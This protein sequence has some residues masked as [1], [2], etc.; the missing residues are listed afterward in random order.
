LLKNLVYKI[1]FVILF[2]NCTLYAKKELIESQPE[3]LFQYDKL[4]KSHEDLA[5]QVEFN[6]A[7][8]QLEK[9]NY[10]DAIEILKRTSAVLPVPSYLN[11]G[12][13]YYKLDSIDNA[14]V[15]LNK[16]YENEASATDNTYSY[17][18]ACFYLYQISK[19]NKYLDTIVKVAKR[20]KKL[21][22]H[23]KRMLADT[24]IILKEYRKS[25]KVLDK[26]DFAMDL[27]KALIHIKLKNYEK[28]NILLQK[29]QE[30]TVNP[31]TLNQILW[32]RVFLDLKS[33]NIERLRENLDNITERKSIFKSNQDLPLEIYFNQNKYTP[34]QYLNFVT[35]FSPD[36]KMD[37]IFYFAPFIFSDSQE[38]IYDSS[39]GFIFNSRDNLSNL[40]SMVEYNAKFLKLVKEDPIVRVTQLKKLLTTDNKSYIYYN[41][42]LSYAHIS[43]FNN[44]FKY[45]QKAYKLNPGNKLYAAMTLI[46][47]KRL[48]I[49]LKDKDYIDN[50]IRT[51]EGMYN[52]FGK[53]LYKLFL[54][55]EYAFDLKTNNYKNTIFYK[56]LDYLKKLNDGKATVDHPLLSKHFKDPLTYLMRLVYRKKGESSYSYYS[57]LQDTIPLSI[58]NNFLEGPLIITQYYVDV[59]KSLGLLKKADLNINGKNTPSYLRT[60]ALRDLHFNKPDESIK[61][62]EYLQKEY[63]LED[64][65]TMY[66]LV[67]ALLDA[68]RYNDASVQISL[69]K[70]ILNDKDADFLT[71][72]QLIQDLKFSSAKQFISEP[73]LDSLIDFK[74]VGF[75]EYLESL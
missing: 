32:F 7:V 36:R 3:I 64:R 18:S 40:E 53:E 68:G 73:Y 4:I 15:Y 50:V 58:N 20:F 10:N 48:K 70:A 39:K 31:N 37:F 43:D 67:A 28:A 66:M 42:A 33:N 17:M 49:K 63:G 72:V 71:A 27:K 34:K 16:I 29:A 69:I 19:D 21:S 24:Y 54:N 59:L 60:K 35:K 46:T 1:L 14:I 62:L 30:E 51:K 25:L 38:V 56:A 47:A 75:D 9:Q 55:P 65:Y 23:S 45:F 22:E 44:A 6:K 57:R 52:Y 41:L 11:I 8:L 5:L 12:I 61:T 26:M 13:A 74:L 2:F